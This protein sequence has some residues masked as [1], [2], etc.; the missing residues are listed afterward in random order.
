MPAADRLKRVLFVE[1]EPELCSA[2]ER[3]FR[4]RWETAFAM[5]GAE[6]LPRLE[7]FAPDVVVLDMRLPD[8]DGIEVLREIRRRRPSLPVII[9]T[10]YASM[11]PLVDVMGMG[12]SGYLLKPYSL[13]DLAEKIDA[14]R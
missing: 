12:H 6:A 10:A 3:Y 14:A 13:T 5:T 4:G 11:E 8:T 1:D 9:T 7:A 2:Y